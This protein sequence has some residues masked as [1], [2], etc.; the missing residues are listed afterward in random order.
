MNVFLLVLSTKDFHH[1]VVDFVPEPLSGYVGAFHQTLF[2][3]RVCNSF[4]VRI[5][6]CSPMCG[7]LFPSMWRILF[8]DKIKMFRNVSCVN[9]T[10][11]I[12]VS[13]LW[14]RHKISKRPTPAHMSGLNSVSL[15][16]DSC[17]SWMWSKC[18]KA[19]GVMLL[20]SLWSRYKNVKA[21]FPCHMFPETSTSLLFDKWSQAVGLIWK[22]DPGSTWW[23]S[24]FSRC[25]CCKLFSPIHISFVS[26]VNL[27][28]LSCS[29][30]QCLIWAPGWIL[31][32]RLCSRCKMS[33]SPSPCHIASLDSESILLERSRFVHWWMW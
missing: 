18:E 11:L 16:W 14:L 29:C 5:R 24:L 28:L 33:N 13:C 15:L 3:N 31:L 12:V 1:N 17:S 27:L 7:K 26:L 22:K 4:P 21:V 6:E 19:P 8:S 23:M 30:S 2:Q 25:R 20:I 9:A 32:T 10:D